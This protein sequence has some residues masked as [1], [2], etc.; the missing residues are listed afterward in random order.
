MGYQLIR[1]HFETPVHVGTSRA[2]YDRVAEWMHSDTLYSAIIQ[3]WADLGIDH[4]AFEIS[5]NEKRPEVL[6]AIP[7]DFTLSS[8]FPF[9]SLQGTPHYFFPAPLG[10]LALPKL[11]YAAQKRL[12]G[13]RF[14]ELD[15]FCEYLTDGAKAGFLPNA[16]DLAYQDLLVQHPSA[17]SA[18]F[19]DR[20]FYQKQ[21][22][23]RSVVPR[24]GAVATDTEIFYL[25]QLTFAEGSGLFGLVHTE[26]EQAEQRLLAALRYLQ[27]EGLGSDRHVGMGQFRLEVAPLPP[28]LSALL[29]GETSATHRLSLSLLHPTHEEVP[30]LLDSPTV[31]Y[32]LKKRGGWIGHEPYLS[33]R[34]N[35]IQMLVEGSILQSDQAFA[36][37][38]VNLR[39]DLEQLGLHVA[40]PI[41]RIGRAMLLPIHLSDY[42]S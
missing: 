27:D 40:H 25:Q 6:G 13:V 14:L 26:D 11:R 20:G 38:T 5:A 41:F 2:E 8:L 23:P 35:A 1:L 7:W 17:Y 29:T 42:E 15:P 16:P 37:T 12:H 32:Q 33:L 19:Q 9:A 4:P 34:K 28:A 24:E 36:G 21:M 30:Q 39:P 22:V 3:A 18:S 31:R 10:G